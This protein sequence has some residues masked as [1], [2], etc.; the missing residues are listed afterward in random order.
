MQKHREYLQL[1]HNKNI[2]L[3]LDKGVAVGY[4]IVVAGLAFRLSERLRT[5]SDLIQGNQG[6]VTDL[7]Q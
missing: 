6:S 2:P 5:T 4:N 7:A 1:V 3:G